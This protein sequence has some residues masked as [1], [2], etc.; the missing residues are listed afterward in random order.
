M[1]RVERRSFLKSRV[2]S[3]F[4]FFFLRSKLS[5]D[6]MLRV[7]ERLALRQVV[8]LRARKEREEVSTLKRGKK[9]ICWSQIAQWQYLRRRETTKEIL[10]EISGLGWPR[11]RAP[12]L[13]KKQQYHWTQRDHKECKLLRGNHK[14]LLKPQD[15]CRPRGKGA[16]QI[17]TTT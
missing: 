3:F 10:G 6:I 2:P 13:G 11:T 17:T 4:P 14:D 12:S 7:W 1:Y 8:A 9:W 16:G 5:K 15:I